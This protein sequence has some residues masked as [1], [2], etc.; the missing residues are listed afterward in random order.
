MKYIVFIFSLIISLTF[1][2]FVSLKKDNLNTTEV[3]ALNKEGTLH[4]FN[5]KFYTNSTFKKLETCG[6]QDKNTLMGEFILPAVRS[7][8]RHQTS[9]YEKK[10]ISKLKAKDIQN[11]TNQI[12]LKSFDE[13][14]LKIT[15]LTF[16]E[17]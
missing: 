3:H 8:V 7:A 5:I 1:T 17:F 11:E 9:L 15:K 12:L 16:S 6:I 4:K 14:K 2:S 13:C 10:E